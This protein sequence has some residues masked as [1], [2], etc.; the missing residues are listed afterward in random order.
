MALGST[1]TLTEMSTRNLPGVKGRPARGADNLTAI[2]KPIVQKMWEPRRLITPWAFTAC[3]RDS[4]TFYVRMI[5]SKMIMNV[6]YVEMQ[7]K[8]SWP[9]LRCY[10]STY[11]LEEIGKKNHCNHMK[12]V[13]LIGIGTGYLQN[14]CPTCCLFGN[15]S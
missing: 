4:F 15:D 1:Q 3:Y 2:Y 14:S 5:C 9:I 12:I 7:G 11:V 10:P 13:F 8:R 6:E